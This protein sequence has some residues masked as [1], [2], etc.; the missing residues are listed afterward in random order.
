MCAHVNIGDSQMMKPTLLFD[1]PESSLRFGHLLTNASQVNR[2]LDKA[3]V[4]LVVELLTFF[5]GTYKRVFGM[6]D[7]PLHDPCAV[8]WVR[9]HVTPAAT[10]LI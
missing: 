2:K 7:P 10:S 8:A 5:K 6:D 1:L 9:S 4:K 3:C